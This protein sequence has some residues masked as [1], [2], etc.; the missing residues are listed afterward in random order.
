MTVEKATQPVTEEQAFLGAIQQDPDDDGR[1]L[2]FADWLDE[3]GD[4]GRAEFIRV[5]C[6]LARTPKYD[7]RRPALEQRE[8]SLPIRP[9]TEWAK[10]LSAITREYEFRRGFVEW[11]AIGARKFLTHGTKLFALAPIRYVKLL[12]LGSSNVASL[13]LADN[14]LLARLRGLDLQGR[15]NADD[16]RTLLTSPHLTRLGA[17]AFPNCD[18]EV[19]GL[20][21]LLNGCLGRLETLDLGLQERRDSE[22]HR[23]GTAQVESLAEA[24][25]CRTLR[26]LSFKNHRINVGGAVAL[27]AA[28][29]LKELRRLTLHNCGI[30]LAGTTALANSPHLN[31]LAT[32]DLRRNKLGDRA[33]QALATARGLPALEELYLGMNELGLPAV[34]ALIGWPGLAKLRLLHLY[35]NP[36]GDEG[37]I[38]LASCPASAGLWHLDLL[39]TEM[40]ERGARALAES[41]YLGQLRCLEVGCPPG[42]GA[43][44]LRARFGP[45]WRNQN[46]I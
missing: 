43:K 46:G 8:Q 35:C 2:V 26:Q 24:R 39:G 10:P 4:P 37:V 30:G 19:A 11:V 12:R 22:S 33:V 38:A 15:L 45:V 9:Q 17:L 34:E 13:D 7:S 5:Q 14:P 27:A 3:H 16:L 41:P 36:I 25:W 28:R 21:P 40:G 6:A 44:A 18:F 32:L 31:K 29:Q 42:A 23:F 20:E 1:R